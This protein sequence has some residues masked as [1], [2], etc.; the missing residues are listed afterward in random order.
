MTR[1]R[2]TPRWRWILPAF[3]T[4]ALAVPVGFTA[5]AQD[6]GPKERKERRAERGE[7]RKER[8]ERKRG[9]GMKA[10]FKDVNLTEEQREEVKD[11]MSPLREEMEA[12]HAKVK[13]A[14]EA[15]RAAMKE[16]REAGDPEA[17]KAA[18]EKAKAEMEALLEERPKVDPYLD[19]VRDILTADQQV[20]FDTN[21]K[22]IEAK[23]A[24]RREQAKEKREERK[25]R[26][27]DRREERGG[28][29]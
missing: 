11:I 17:A 19:D 24:E 14:R 20:T 26:R 13:E 16:A 28:P 9:A 23:M 2:N 29:E 3:A 8:G 5:V 4:L 27:G 25:E 18:R 12:W 15:N 10:L 6:A 21:R 7:E 1:S 22:A